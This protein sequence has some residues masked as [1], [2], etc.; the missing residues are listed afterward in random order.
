MS[1][2][3][4]I[5]QKTVSLVCPDKEGKAQIE[6]AAAALR[7]HTTTLYSWLRHGL[8]KSNAESL[9]K[10]IYL[11]DSLGEPLTPEEILVLTAQSDQSEAT[12]PG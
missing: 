9:A 2:S 11:R 4:A 7:V 6:E 5:I 3:A 8:Q 12:T 1:R 10:L